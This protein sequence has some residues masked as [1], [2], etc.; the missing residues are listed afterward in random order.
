[1][2]TNT[3]D[4]DVKPPPKPARSKGKTKDTA[5][6]EASQPPAQTISY[7]EDI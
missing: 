6:D 3:E 4:I 2:K 5:K 7:Y 1:M